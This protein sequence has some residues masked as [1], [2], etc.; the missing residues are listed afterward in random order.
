MNNH[1]KAALGIIL[2]L[3]TLPLLSIVSSWYEEVPE[4]EELKEKMLPDAYQNVVEIDAGSGHICV[5]L[6]DGSV[7]CWGGNGG[8]QLGDGTNTGRYTPTQTSSLG[9]GRTAIAISAGWG[10]TCAILDDGSV[11]CW[12]RNDNGQLGDNTTTADRNT[13]TQTS[14]LG[15]DRTAVAISAGMYH[16]CAILDDGSVSCWGHNNYGQLGDGTITQR[17]TP[18]QTSSLGEGRTAVAITAGGHHTCAILDDGSVSC[19]GY[20]GYGQLGVGTN[21][22][23]GTGVNDDAYTP[24]Q[25]SSLG[26]DRTAVA[27]AAGSDYTCAILDDGSV[28]CWGLNGYGQLGDGT[29]TDRNTPTQTSSL[30]TDRTAVAIS[31]GKYHTCAIL[32]DRSVSCWGANGFGQLGDDSIASTDTDGDGIDDDTDRHTPTQTSSLGTDRTAVAISVGFFH[33]CAILDDGSVSCWGY[34]SEGQLG[35]GTTTNRNTPTLVTFPEVP[36]T[37]VAI[38]AEISTNTLSTGGDGAC[39]ITTGTPANESQTYCWGGN[40]D[41]QLGNGMSLVSIKT[42]WHHSCGINSTGSVYCWGNNDKGQLGVPGDGPDAVYYS[43][44]PMLV[45]LDQPAISLGL[46]RDFSCA[47]TFDNLAGHNYGEEIGSSRVYCWGS[48][49]YDNCA[50]LDLIYCGIPQWISDENFWS[51]YDGGPPSDYFIWEVSAGNEHACA[52]VADLS[53]VNPSNSTTVKD[54]SNRVYCWGS[55]NLYQLGSDVSS[56]SIPIQADL[57]DDANPI[58]IAAGHQHTCAL[59]SNGSVICWGDNEQGA[60]GNGEEGLSASNAPDYAFLGGLEAVHIDAERHSCA[61]MSGGS[62]Y[63]WGAGN[64]GSDISN[65]PYPQNRTLPQGEIAVSVAAGGPHGGSWLYD[66]HTC[67]TTLNGS[68]LCWGHDGDFGALGYDEG[69]GPHVQCDS[70]TEGEVFST[71][72]T[73]IVDL[74]PVLALIE[75]GGTGDGNG[76]NNQTYDGDGDGI[77]DSLDLCP[78]T[79]DGLTVDSNG[80]APYQKDSDE[81]GVTDDIDSCPNTNQ[82]SSVDFVGCALYQ[83]DTDGD[84]RSDAVDTC[85]NTNQGSSVDANGCAAYQKDT[86]EDGRSDAVDTCPNTNQ[87]S[88]VDANG[89]ADYQLDSDG[90]SV[91]DSLDLCPDTTQSPVDLDGC[92]SGQLDDDEDGISNSEDMCLFTPQGASIDSEGCQI[93]TTL[94]CTNQNAN[95]YNQAATDD[96]GTCDFDLDDDGILDVD[97]VEGQGESDTTTSDT[98]TNFLP[99]IIVVIVGLIGVT[100]V[101]RRGKSENIPEII[102]QTQE[103]SGIESRFRKSELIGE[104]GMA[105]VFRATEIGGGKSVVWKEAAA[106]RF[107]PLPEVNR[108]LLDESEILSNLDH[109]RI[110]KHLEYSEFENTD[111]DIVGVMIMEHIDG[112]SLKNDSDTLLK[113]NRNFTL[114]EATKIIS[115]I[116][117]PLD[118]MADLE[119]PIYHRDIKPANIIIEPTRGPVLIDFGLAKG[120]DAGTDVSLSQGLSE[121]WSPPERRDGISGAFTDVFSLGQTLWHI[122]TGE[123]P[124]HALTKEEIIEKLVEKDHPEWVAEV[125]LASA[126]RYDRR[127]QSVFEFR[128]MLENEGKIVK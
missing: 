88:S 87:G 107:N 52:L 100:V 127:I 11:S 66:G 62:L 43:Q 68:T 75:Q 49:E 81:D 32:D 7:S 70:C 71:P 42:G 18:T 54:T 19:W 50:D 99:Y 53:S 51:E 63:C 110:P 104:G 21:D 79:T 45:D 4:L 82:G 38:A 90:D 27:I 58:Q 116:C 14:S 57:P 2:I 96:D 112:N 33:T 76:T 67:V 97:E 36:V 47:V 101:L 80:C 91:T 23:D 114:K 102:T 125:I 121:G 34:N 122:L 13:P 12:G 40:G 26:T 15:T 69:E 31:A 35:D 98:L 123:R 10:H 5:I 119:I 17:N 22:D 28:S 24:T 128:L 61:V 115:Q 124:F 103:T 92:S 25:T 73:I 86:D 72:G 120:V 64:F 9:E 117:E 126:Q 93:F 74:Q 37:A 94:G 77:I 30:G 111:G 1:F 95:N 105:N 118:Y 109:P 108:R 65:S 6:D 106:S 56:N 16:T 41:G 8:G 46:G 55:N 60:I 59:F 83:K 20:D 44:T 85:P 29:T 89:C 84:G 113:M 39:A 78:G 3:L 48:D